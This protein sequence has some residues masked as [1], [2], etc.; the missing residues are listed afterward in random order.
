MK[1]RVVVG[2]LIEHDGKILMGRKAPGKGPY[3]DTWHMPGGGVNLESE[4]LIEGV[5]REIKEETGLEVKEIERLGF[6]ED[7]ESNSHGEMVHYVFLIFKVISTTN[8][9]V[10]GDD[11]VEIK[12]FDRSELKNLALTRPSKKIFKELGWI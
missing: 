7:N 1:Y 10:P 2:A 8:R 11:I 9:A 3:P 6:D 4:T 12:W 5:T